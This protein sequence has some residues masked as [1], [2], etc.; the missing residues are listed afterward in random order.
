ME[1]AIHS[2]FLNLPKLSNA[3]FLALKETSSRWKYSTTQINSSSFFH[4]VLLPS[5]MGH[6]D[7]IGLEI[8]FGFFSHFGFCLSLSCFLSCGRSLQFICSQCSPP[9]LSLRAQYSRISAREPSKAKRLACL[10][11]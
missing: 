5:S 11:S 6:G 7:R 10:L 3:L 2:S 9:P 1:T 4:L 8:L